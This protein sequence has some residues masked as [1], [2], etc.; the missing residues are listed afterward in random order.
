MFTCC[1]RRSRRTAPATSS[2]A[3]RAE[4]QHATV[5]RR[6]VL[7]RN[8]REDRAPADTAATPSPA[9]PALAA[10]IESLHQEAAAELDAFIIGPGLPR[11]LPS[12]RGY[13]VVQMTTQNHNGVVT[14]ITTSRRD[15]MQSGPMPLD[16]LPVFSDHLLDALHYTMHTRERTQMMGDDNEARELLEA[17]RNPQHPLWWRHLVHG[18]NQDE[19]NELPLCDAST[20]AN[21]NDD[22]G[23]RICLNAFNHDDNEQQQQQ[24]QKLR[25]LPCGHKFHQECAD[26]WLATNA[27]CP[28]CKQSIATAAGVSLK[29]AT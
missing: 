18:A 15:R 19:I 29:R 20:A 26:R 13:T 5:A 7:R 4:Q 28:V 16:D 21:E 9:L 3:P 8:E 23:C 1:G 25:V 14:M 27:T 24:Q 22:G 6:A 12:P 11:L 2:N 10:V 17:R